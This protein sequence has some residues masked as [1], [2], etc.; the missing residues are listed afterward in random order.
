M[1]PKVHNVSSAMCVN[2]VIVKGTIKSIVSKS[3][4]NLLMM[5]PV[6]VTSKKWL[7]ERRMFNSSVPCKFIDARKRPWPLMMDAISN[8]NAYQH[9]VAP[10]NYIKSY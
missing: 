2:L 4:E 1:T 3:L 8:K 7:G 5:R 10:L 9:C 6:G